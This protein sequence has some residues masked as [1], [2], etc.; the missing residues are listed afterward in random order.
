MATPSASLGQPLSLVEMAVEIN[1][2]R[3]KTLPH[4][5]FVSIDEK[6]IVIDPGGEIEFV[7]LPDAIRCAL[8]TTMITELGKAGASPNLSRD[9]LMCVIDFNW[10]PFREGDRLQQL[11]AAF[12]ATFERTP[13]CEGSSTGPTTRSQ[14]S[15]VPPSASSSDSPQSSAS[16][17]STGLS[18]SS[19]APEIDDK[20]WLDPQFKIDPAD[21][22]VIKP[23]RPKS[24]IALEDIK[25]GQ[26][27]AR[28]ANC[29]GILLCGHV[30]P[31]G[32]AF[33]AGTEG[34]VKRLLDGRRI[35]AI[36]VRQVA[37]ALRILGAIYASALGP[38]PKTDDEKLP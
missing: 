30:C 6:R 34:P 24:W 8:F 37:S 22:V 31:C 2:I 29:D 21:V 3:P 23:P 16:A 28:C 38:P 13:Q 18:S 25:S 10:T 27:V 20:G 15:S 5:L 19:A 33:Y 26:F 9:A 12:K 4:W 17:S 7:D 1:R 36:D 35:V 11:F 14:R 32:S